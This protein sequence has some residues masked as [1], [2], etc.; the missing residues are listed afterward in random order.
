MLGPMERDL[1]VAWPKKN[2]EKN[3][4]KRG[5][6]GKIRGFFKAFV[7]LIGDFLLSTIGNHH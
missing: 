3:P 1:M 4:T 2:T 6:L 5:R 7:C